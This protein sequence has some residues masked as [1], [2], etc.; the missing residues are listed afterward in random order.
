MGASYRSRRKRTY[1]NDP[2]KYQFT[3]TDPMV[4]LDKVSIPG[5]W[6]FGGKDIQIPVGMCIENLNGLK[7]K[8]KDFEYVLF[9]ELGHNTAAATYNTTC[10][11]SNPLDSKIR[12]LI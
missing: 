9:S 4:S 7:G 6:I 10:R 3:A 5:I 8:G 12:V 2:D 1:K 11:Y